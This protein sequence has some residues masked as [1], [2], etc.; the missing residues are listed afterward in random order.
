MFSLKFSCSLFL[1]IPS[2]APCMFCLYLDVSSRFFGFVLPVGWYII[3][4]IHRSYDWFL[5]D[6]LK[7]RVDFSASVSMSTWP[8]TTSKRCGW[9]QVAAFMAS[10]WT[11]ARCGMGA[12]HPPVKFYRISMGF[13]WNFY[14]ILWKLK[15]PKKDADRL[16]PGKH[17]G[18]TNE[19]PSWN[20]FAASF[21]GLLYM[22][23]Y[24]CVCSSWM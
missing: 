1:L 12:G 10:E 11:A 8:F 6:P 7:Q 2:I 16:E 21:F 20:H 14:W 15:H 23:K 3:C 9:N 5:N 22:L 4:G 13:I 19:L 24:H 18:A 17:T